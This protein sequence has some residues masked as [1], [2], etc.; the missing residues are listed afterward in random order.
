MKNTMTLHEAKGFLKGRLKLIKS[1]YP[2]ID[3]YAEALEVAITCIDRQIAIENQTQ[4][5][6]YRRKGER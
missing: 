1:D 4:A 5:D 3:D 6:K 2:G